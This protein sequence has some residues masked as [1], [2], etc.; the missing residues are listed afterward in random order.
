MDSNVIRYKVKFSLW[1]CAFAETFGDRF[2]CRMPKLWRKKKYSFLS[3]IFRL[4]V[5]FTQFMCLNISI[6]IS[7]YFVIF[8]RVLTV[9][10]VVLNSMDLSI[11]FILNPHKKVNVGFYFIFSVDILFFQICYK[12]FDSLI[13]YSFLIFKTS[14]SFELDVCNG[15]FSALHSY[16]QLNMCSYYKRKFNYF[17]VL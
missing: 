6:S 2:L 14:L 10:R 9:I 16:L 12:I 3:M 17:K 7:Q 8:V 13:V 5:E 11:S 4:K 15:E 1:R